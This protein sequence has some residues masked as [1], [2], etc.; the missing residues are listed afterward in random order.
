MTAL[1]YIVLVFDPSQVSGH[2]QNKDPLRTPRPVGQMPL[3]IAVDRSWRGVH[4]VG[5]SELHLRSTDRLT[6]FVLVVAFSRSQQLPASISRRKNFQRCQQVH[7]GD[8]IFQ[9]KMVNHAQLVCCSFLLG[10]PHVCVTRSS[11]EPFILQDFGL[12]ASRWTFSSPAARCKVLL[13]RLRRA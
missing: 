2:S 4:C 8:N 9:M 10:E 6:F 13:L 3:P 11:H 1:I 12:P 5:L 7:R